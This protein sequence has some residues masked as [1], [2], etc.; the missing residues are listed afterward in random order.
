M[1]IKH[2]SPKS[3]NNNPNENSI[4]NIGSNKNSNKLSI[5]KIT[6]RSSDKQNNITSPKVISLSINNNNINN[7][8][9]ST[10]TLTTTTTQQQNEKV[11][12]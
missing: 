6:L 2:I 5:T 1:S 7:N 11:I 10:T 4:N 9:L 8:N 12:T 3:I